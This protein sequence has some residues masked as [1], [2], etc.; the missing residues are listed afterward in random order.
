[1][2]GTT[3]KAFTADRVCCRWRAS[4]IPMLYCS[5]SRYLKKSGYEVAQEIRKRPR[6]QRV[7]LIGI[8][9]Q[10]KQGSD[11]ILANISGFDHYLVKPFDPAALLALLAEPIFRSGL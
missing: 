3:C 2:R 11:R 10:Y 8:S 6:G 7:L 4:L 9:G 1:M 5:T